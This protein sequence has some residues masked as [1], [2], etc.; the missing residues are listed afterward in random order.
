[1]N[2]I[3]PKKKGKGTFLYSGCT[4]KLESSDEMIFE[5]PVEVVNMSVTI[6]SIL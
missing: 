5:V 1:L 4:V 3:N 2:L 6:K